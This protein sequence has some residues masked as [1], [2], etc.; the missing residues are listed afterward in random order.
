MSRI[1]K[2]NLNRVISYLKRNGLRS[3]LINISERLSRD[4]D[5]A[6]YTQKVISNRASEEELKEQRKR[7][8]KR[9]VKVSIL[10]PAYETEE[11]L[12]LETIESVAKQSYGNWELCIADA[13]R[14]DSRRILIKEYISQNTLKYSDDFG[15]LN[16]KIKYQHL[17]KN[18]GISGNTNEALKMATGDYIALLDHDDLLEADTLF[19][20]MSAMEEAETRYN[21]GVESFLKIQVVYCDEDKI[22]YDNTRYFDYHKKPDFNPY[23]LCTN[24]YIC[25]F[26]MVDAS[27]AKSVEGF[28]SEFD[29]AQDHDF[30]FRC[31]EGLSRDRI[32]HV[33][34]ALYHWRSTPNST[35]ENPEA[36]LYAYQAG[37]RAIEE[38]LK[39]VGV[40]AKVKETEHMG[41]FDV[42]FS[43]KVPAEAV[44]MMKLSE[45]KASSEDKLS[46]IDSKYVLILSEDYSAI[47]GETLSIL[48]GPMENDD[49]GAVTGRIVGKNSRLESAGYDK[50][51]SGQF[52]PRFKGLNKNYSGYLHRAKM[53]QKVDGFDE[54]FVL[55]RK[56]SV[57]RWLP[58]IELKDKYDIFFEPKVE[59]K[60][61]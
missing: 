28:H 41:F 54:G 53:Q 8:F 2:K 56:D 45:Y 3:S 33:P 61:K 39:R 48:C 52:V 37:K 34:K 32:V 18:Q 20:Y 1:N 10:L 57:K 21:N 51:E 55:I 47:S 40:L 38:H 27:L 60:R 6:N 4:N 19:Q 58:K 59:I 25:H 17:E 7:K 11:N 15:R 24:N 13:S 49:V 23:L 30:V 50:I 29:G 35:A 16:D 12:L 36:K 26:L 31:T 9:P 44:Q 5:E 22:A 46:K 14:N 42:E 43:T